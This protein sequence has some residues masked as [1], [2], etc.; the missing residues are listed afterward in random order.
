MTKVTWENVKN[1]VEQNPCGTTNR[2]IVQALGNEAFY[3]DVCCI[4]RLL[5]AAG[6]ID[7]WLFANDS[8]GHLYY[9][10]GGV[11]HVNGY[12]PKGATHGQVAG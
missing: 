6:E 9:P 5:A 10:R 8:P 1:I 11:V 2:Q 4:T 3:A 12:Q 7:V